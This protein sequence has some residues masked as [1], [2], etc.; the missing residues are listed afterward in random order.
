MA[1]EQTLASDTTYV[2]YMPGNRNAEIAAE[3]DAAG[4][5]ADVPCIII[6]RA[7]TQGETLYRTTVGKLVSCPAASA[8]SLLVVGT[9]AGAAADDKIKE[10]QVLG[11]QCPK[12]MSLAR[13]HI[14]HHGNGRSGV[15]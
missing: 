7:T 4:V 6:S 9:V 11:E 15:E 14:F 2:I 12:V 1:D 13:E 3:L 10:G 8:P 5:A